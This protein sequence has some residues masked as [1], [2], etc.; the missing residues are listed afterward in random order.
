MAQYAVCSF[1]V[2]PNSQT[3]ENN[4][5]SVKPLIIGKNGNAFIACT[6]ALPTLD[7]YARAEGAGGMPGE[8]PLDVCR[9]GG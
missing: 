5:I 3:M 1:H 9:D 8:V 4:N 6:P 2:H 7:I